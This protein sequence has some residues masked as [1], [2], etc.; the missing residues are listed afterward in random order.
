MTRKNA[1]ISVIINKLVEIE[2]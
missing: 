2:N 1:L